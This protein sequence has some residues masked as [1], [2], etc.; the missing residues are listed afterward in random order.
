[1]TIPT[2]IKIYHH[3]ND[4]IFDI[5]E[6][7]DLLI[8]RA[9]QSLHQSEDLPDKI[10][11][12]NNK[13]TLQ[14][15]YIQARL[16][17]SRQQNIHMP[18]DIIANIFNLT[19]LEVELILICLLPYID[20]YYDNI[21]GSLQTNKSTRYPCLNLFY[22]LLASDQF[23]K[24][25][26]I[27]ER[28]LPNATL[29]DWQLLYRLNANEPL[30]VSTDITLDAA[31]VNY[32][33]GISAFEPELALNVMMSTVQAE[34]SSPKSVNPTLQ[35]QIAA[36]NQYMQA[37]NAYHYIIHC[38]GNDITQL[39]KFA[40]Q[41]I[42]NASSTTICKID[43][44]YLL[45]F[46]AG[47]KFNKA[48]IYKKLKWLFRAI[49]LTA[50][51]PCITN[52][53]QLESDDIEISAFRRFL[54]ES[55]SITFAFVLL[56]G[57]KQ[58]FSA[59]I[60]DEINFDNARYIYI[61]EP[62]LNFEQRFE[63]WQDVLQ[64]SELQQLKPLADIL[65]DKFLFTASQIHSVKQHVLNQ[66]I[67]TKTVINTDDLLK[68][69]QSHNSLILPNLATKISMKFKLSE[70]VLPEK[71]QAEIK[72]ICNRVKFKR[73]VYHNW[74]FIEK[75]KSQ[76][77]GLCVMFHGISGT[78]KTMTAC[79]I[80]SSLDQEL[81][82][83]NLAMM[84]SKYI[85]ETEKNLARIF[86]EAESL[87]AIL[88]FDEADAIFGKRAE[89]KDAH[90]KFANIQTGYLLQ[91]IETYQGIVILATNL[92]KNIDEAFIRRLDFIVEFPFPDINQREQL[93]KNAFPEQA[94]LAKDIDYQF[95]AT[96]IKLAG[97]NIINIALRAAFYAIEKAEQITM[98]D[99]LL[100]TKKEYH[101][102]G[103][104]FLET[105]FAPY[106]NYFS[107]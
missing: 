50:A 26:Q 102:I 51:Y 89:V 16:S 84:V 63:I 34:D 54:L 100:A 83:I 20:D 80:A 58:I 25:L 30:T 77:P 98:Q 96:K 27:R 1:M 53:E 105:D 23:D 38:K 32:L 22:L 56:I 61:D 49:I 57:K 40:F 86:D 69:C 9:Q 46:L 79:A 65:A 99:I 87:N 82:T 13:I 36:L 73:N 59:P 106:D 43:A 67:L 15:S 101:K 52:F 88:F 78:G 76:R 85:G 95:L 3:I 66:S 37:Y 48:F 64:T 6:K 81:Y 19:P 47:N 11:Y 17:L 92:L 90:D 62:M 93:W 5:C 33:L 29:M 8:E 41:F 7:F 28:L 21:Y 18:I 75:I 44:H 24:K 4:Y 10:A 2:D 107:N 94:P 91:R 45:S 35:T 74:G 72:E 70:V 55:L 14:D 31:M 42:Q 71:T 39:E 103:I 104:G 97:G 68:A 12:L 60:H